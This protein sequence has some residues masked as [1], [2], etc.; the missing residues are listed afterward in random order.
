[1]QV[2]A[3]GNYYPHALPAESTRRSATESD[4]VAA[5]RVDKFLKLGESIRFSERF[6]S[7]RTPDVAFNQHFQED[8][9]KHRKRDISEWIFHADRR[10]KPNLMLTRSLST[11]QPRKLTLDS[12]AMKSRSGSD[13]MVALPYSQSH[14]SVWKPSWQLGPVPPLVSR[15]ESVRAVL[16]SPRPTNLGATALHAHAFRSLCMS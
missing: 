1:M 6:E 8:P 10:L 12:G 9:A 3:G 14:A 11:P 13:D 16:L 4:G 2:R 15:H 7:V 5:L